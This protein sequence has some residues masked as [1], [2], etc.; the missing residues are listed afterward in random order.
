MSPLS[1][2]PLIGGGNSNLNSTMSPRTRA[3]ASRPGSTGSGASAIPATPPENPGERFPI[4]A[5]ADQA[6]GV[7]PRPRALAVEG[8]TDDHG[9]GDGVQVRHLQE[10]LQVEGMHAP[11][12][13]VS[14]KVAMC[15]SLFCWED[16]HAQLWSHC[17]L[18]FALRGVAG[19]VMF[20]QVG[21]AKNLDG[22]LSFRVCFS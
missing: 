15:V 2:S 9:H 16:P 8:T 21:N 22:K 19:H 13:S 11:R 12:T 18:A 17:G 3:S 1:G 10:E 14:L 6:G 20:F 7:L 4:S 5:L